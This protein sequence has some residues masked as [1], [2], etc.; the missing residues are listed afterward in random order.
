[1]TNESELLINIVKQNELKMLTSLSQKANGWLIPS[2]MGL[3][4][5]NSHR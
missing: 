2:S 3:R 5:H 1:M 4:G